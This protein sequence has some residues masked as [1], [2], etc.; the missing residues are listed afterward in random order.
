M[1]KTDHYIR[2]I[3][4]ILAI[5]FKEQSFT[6]GLAEGM[7]MVGEGTHWAAIDCACPEDQLVYECSVQ[8]GVATVWQG[9]AF[10]CG[11]ASDNIIL[12]H[13]RSNSVGVCNN[14]RLMAQI[15]EAFNGTFTSQLNIT[16]IE[17]MNN[18]TIECAVEYVNETSSVI[19]MNT[20]I[21]ALGTPYYYYYL[22]NLTSLV[23]FF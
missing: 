21:T 16:V 15:V 23:S 1:P 8:G 13:S 22:T 18:K 6:N 20:I 2:V 9:S 14:G 7:S 4:A 19:N 10:D 11:L 12:R 3:L 5:C 17:D